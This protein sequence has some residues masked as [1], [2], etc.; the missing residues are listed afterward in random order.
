MLTPDLSPRVFKCLSFNL[1]SEFSRLELLQPRKSQRRKLW[2]EAVG[3]FLL[4]EASRQIGAL[5][6]FQ[7]PWGCP[8]LAT[9]QKTRTSSPR[10]ADTEVTSCPDAFLVCP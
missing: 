1:S 8:S 9:E 10:E 6:P 4:G 3:D 7:L 2:S 5:F